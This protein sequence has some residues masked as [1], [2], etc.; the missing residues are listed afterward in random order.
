MTKINAN[1]VRKLRE[2]R[3]LTLDGLAKQANID[4]GTISK[5]ENGKRAEIRNSTLRKLANGLGVEV[6]TLTGLDVEKVDQEPPLARKAQM[7]FKMADDARNAL[8][9]TALRY[10]VKPGHILHLAPFL[11]YW[12][13]EAS[14]KW[15]Q[16]HLDEIYEKVDALSNL[17]SM[18]HLNN[19]ATHNWS[20][21]DILEDERQ[22]I[23]KR[24]L[25]GALLS[26]DSLS[27]RFEESE[28][29]PM[30]RFLASIAAS[31]GEN[32]EF[33][34]WSPHWSQPGYTLGRKE[35]LELAGGDGDAAHYIVCGTA[36]LHEMPKEVRDQGSSAI[37]KWANELGSARL[38]ELENFDLHAF[39]L[40]G[41]DD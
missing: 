24:D 11:F 41:D 2:Q 18:D 5:I 37:A 7:N 27:E 1:N 10:N 6:E 13:A 4:R 38:Q 15:R 28:Q 36:P 20:G 17:S 40:G 31:L 21:E 39:A 35:A 34:H 32:V 29:N 3:H 8:N 23:A 22:S 19:L 12:A 26:D 30:A 33:E 25:F 16:Q 14:L 9:L